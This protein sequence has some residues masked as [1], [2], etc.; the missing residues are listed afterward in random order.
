M[1]GAAGTISGTRFAQ[2][3]A[4]RTTYD[5]EIIRDVRPF[6]NPWWNMVP[7]GTWNANNGSSLIQNR[8][9]GV[10][11]PM[12]RRWETFAPGT[13]T[14]TPCDPEENEIGYGQT[15]LTYG[16]KRQS[17]RTPMFCFDQIMTMVLA[18]EQLNQI[19]EDIL[20]PATM[21]IVSNMYRVETATMADTKKMAT[22]GM[23]DFD[24]D[25]TYT[26]D[27]LS[28]F[29]VK[30]GT[31]EPTSKLTHEMVKS[32]YTTQMLEGAF[33]KSPEGAEN[34]LEMV[35]DLDTLYEIERTS[36]II[37]GTATGAESWRFRDL[38]ELAKYHKYGWSGAFGNAAFVVD[39]FGL[40]FNKVTAGTFQ[41]VPPY[42]NQQIPTANG[43]GTRSVVNPQWDKANYV[44]HFVYNRRAQEAL[45][46]KAAAQNS[47]MPF[48]VRDF[49][50]NWQFVTNDLGTPNPRKN[51]GY[52]YAD[53]MLGMKP[54]NTEWLE[55]IFSQRDPVVITAV[56]KSTPDNTPAAWTGQDGTFPGCDTT[57]TTFD[58]TFHV[59]AQAA[60]GDLSIP[61]SGISCGARVIANAAL[62]ASD[63][64]GSA[65]LPANAAAITPTELNALITALATNL[66]ADTNAA[67]I[68]TWSNDKS[69]LKLAGSSCASI[70]IAWT[71]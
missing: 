44:M 35:V 20:R 61:A 58:H 56:A 16:L 42:I 55:V 52:F 69:T 1:A 60:D 13:C 41:F 19:I 33:G 3:L 6:D 2:H 8:F 10:D 36:N 24:F 70:T 31:T 7:R 27:R 67:T 65:T 39:K 45:W 59:A 54:R 62:K 49:T 32:R 14:T 21:R 15:Q 71:A 25:W 22:V 23:D 57:G 51:K 4:T 9:R 12:D 48:N 17:W 47:K 5:A 34:M 37:K 40:R 11:A 63:A 28:G 18:K 50:G 68:G 64:A 46:F 38:M 43:G 29:K 66:N 26:N 53:F 30:S